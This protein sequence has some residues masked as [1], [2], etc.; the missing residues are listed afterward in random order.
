MSHQCKSI[1]CD[2]KVA[3]PQTDFCTSCGYVHSILG[4]QNPAVEEAEADIEALELD[5]Y[6]IHHAFQIN[7]P[8]GCLQRASRLI[9][10]TGQMNELEHGEPKAA[11][12]M[13]ARNML[14]RW[15]QLNYYE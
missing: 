14:T 12:I 5:T 7:D 3:N 2:Q 4:M 10:L 11:D 8:S 9:L 6:A 13:E 15:L 1:G